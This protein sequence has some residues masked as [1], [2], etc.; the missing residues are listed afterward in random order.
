MNNEWIKVSHAMYSIEETTADGRHVC[1]KLRVP[2]DAVP[3][4]VGAI[5]DELL[6]AADCYLTQ[7]TPDDEPEGGE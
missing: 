4:T 3:A 2:Y 7:N 5:A 6:R 1:V